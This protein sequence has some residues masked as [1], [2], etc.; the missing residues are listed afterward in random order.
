MVKNRLFLFLIMSLFL[1]SFTSAFEFDNQKE[2]ITNYY[3][4]II[5]GERTIEYNPIWEKYK[6]IEIKNSFGFG[7]TLFK[8]AIEKHTNVCSKNCE[9]I[10]QIE[11][12]GG[13]LVQDI[14]FK[15]SFDGGKTFVDWDSFEGYRI[16]LDDKFYPIGK[17]IS[18]GDYELKIVGWKK[19]STIIDWQIKVQGEWLEEWSTWGN[20]SLGDDSEVILHSPIDNFITLT[21]SVFF[22]ATANVTGGS[23][24]SNLTLYHNFSGSWSS[25]GTINVIGF[26]ATNQSEIE[27]VSTGFSTNSQTG[28]Y[29]E[30]V[31]INQD[32]QVLSV[33]K[34]GAG[35]TVAYI[36]DLTETTTYGT[37]SFSGNIA[38]FSTPVFLNASTTYKFLADNGGASYSRPYKSG[39]SYPVSGEYLDYISNEG[40][41]TT[42]YGQIVTIVVQNALSSVTNFTG[43]WNEEI[44]T[45]IIWNV[46]ACDSD[47]DCGFSNSNFTL[48]IDTIPPEISVAEPN[49]TLSLGMVD[50]TQILN[51][52]FT[53]SNLD[54]CWY[55][56]NG[57]NVSIPGCVSG[58][59]NVTNFTLIQKTNMT[60]YANDTAGNINEVLLE[61]EYDIF[62]INL[63]YDLEVL[64][65]VQ[66]NFTQTLQLNP[67]LL[68]SSALFEYDGINY[69]T[70]IY[71]SGDTYNVSA[72][73]AVPTVT[74]DENKTFQFHYLV[75]GTD[76]S[77]LP[78]NQSVLSI[79]FAVC[80]GVSNDTIVNFSLE[81]EITQISLN[82]T[83]EL[84]VTV[85]SKSS[86]TLV[87]SSNQT[88][89]NVH[90]ASICFSPPE[91]YELYY[92]D[93]QIKYGLANYSTEFYIIQQAG[94]E[95]Y[96]QNITL[97][98]LPLNSSTEFLVRY[99]GSDLLPVE[100]AVIQL[101]RK[102]IGEGVYKLVEA[103]STS[104]DGEATLHIDLDTN[105]YKAIVVKDGIVL[106]IFE[107]LVF[108]C[109]NELS[110][111][112]SKNLLGNI[113]PQNV[114]ANEDLDDFSYT[115]TEVN[116][117]LTTT[118]SIPSGTS[119]AVNVQ[120]SQIDS[121]GNESICN[122]TITSSAGSIECTYSD[123]LV[124][125]YIT[126]SISKEAEPMAK[127][128]YEL[129]PSGGLDWLGNNY[130]FILVLLLSFVG[131]A[132]SSPEW[133]VVNAVLTL[134]VSGGLW[135]ANGLNF[136]TGLGTIVWILISAIILITK[137]SKQEDR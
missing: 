113:D 121:F 108:D 70:S 115:V 22:N 81:D 82:G 79:E 45:G 59:A 72:S 71:Y 11:H 117:T 107:N 9:T 119:S 52:T 32:L 34:T 51:V 110:G 75:N 91:D 125:S 20:I 63:T 37:A 85:S 102:Y 53:D 46:E 56:Y 38:T 31:T 28:K 87:G 73:I 44:T 68:L 15:R 123:S 133:M 8:G 120:M 16:L 42:E 39:A 17:E 29:G 26:N 35:A 104:D 43:T 13:E 4:G 23:T 84:L 65:G 94:L 14:R 135:L 127:L 126:L 124:L 89:T 116:N 33:T 27:T 128:S 112:C 83:I 106:K 1:V 122:Q 25:N 7:K 61:W 19:G 134:V 36:M 103:P 80:G 74:V 60:L 100:A 69:S 47:G 92:L 5:I 86:G 2:S 105:L 6:P 130:L 54:S 57:T 132:V 10:I 62:L 118:F 66:T 111:Q 95:D 49:G 30:R 137:M 50:E 12:D 64:E 98:P 24:L 3:D 136:V 41:D 55:D 131:M 76:Y 88:F 97:Y 90:S 58:V 18:K 48:N 129:R 96:P 93:A 78:R 67:S 99:Q 101:L 40:G 21:T 109:E 114:L 77:S